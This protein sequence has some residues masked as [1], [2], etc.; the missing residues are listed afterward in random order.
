MDLPA[1]ITFICDGRQKALSVTG[2]SRVDFLQDVPPHM[3]KHSSFSA[4]NWLGVLFLREQRT[5]LRRA[6][7]RDWVAAG[8]DLRRWVYGGGKVLP[9]LVNRREAEVKRLNLHEIG[10]CQL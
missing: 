2:N 3:S 1:L 4:V 8:Q 9:G 6:N 10:L 5:P 7:Q